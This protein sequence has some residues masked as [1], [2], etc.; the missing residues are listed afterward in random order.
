MSQIPAVAIAHAADYNR[1]YPGETVT[2]FTRIDIRIPLAGFTLRISVPDGLQPGAFRAAANHDGS[3]P[4]LVHV[5]GQRYF[6]W[7]LRREVRSGER[8]EYQL[9]AV[10][11]PTHHSTE[12]TSRAVML[13]LARSDEADPPALQADSVTIAVAPQGRLL[14]HLPALYA[15]QDE[16]MGRF[17]M[18]FESFWEPIGDRIDHISDYFDTRLAPPDLLPWLATWVDLILDEDWPEEKQRQLL[19]SMVLLYRQRGTRRGLQK[20]LEIYTGQKPE[21]VEHRAQNFRLGPAARL[22][23]SLALGKQN[24]SHTFSVTLLLPAAAS[25]TERKARRRK[26]EAIIDS[27]KPAHTV[28]DLVIEESPTGNRVSRNERTLDR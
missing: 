2:F 8:F 1:R 17:L 9:E 5:D 26:I 25:E 14:R 18:L 15:D 24:V 19:G 16:M 28:Y 27:E 20:Y 3:V 13:L 10:I 12:L 11:A 6:I 21:I 4:H 23:P 22:G 7:E